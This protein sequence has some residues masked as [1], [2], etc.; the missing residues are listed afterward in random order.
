MKIIHKFKACLLMTALLPMMANAQ[1]ATV[2]A[3]DF[4]VEAGSTG[5]IE[6]NLTN[7]DFEVTAVQFDIALPQGLSIPYDGEDYQATLTS[8]SN[9]LILASNLVDGKVRFVM[10]GAL[11]GAVISGSEGAI[12]KITV[13]ADNTFDTGKLTFSTVRISSPT[14]QLVKGS[15]FDVVANPPIPESVEGV[16]LAFEELS[17]PAGGSGVLAIDLINPEYS[18]T[19][20]QFDLTLPYAMSLT[21]IEKTDRPSSKHVVTTK[22]LDSGAIRVKLLDM[23]ANN[24]TIAGKEG[25]ILNLNLATESTF[26]SGKITISNIEMSNPDMLVATPEDITLDVTATAGIENI[27]ADMQ[28]YN[29]Y[30]LQGVKV[31]Q[32]NLKKGVYIINGKKMIVK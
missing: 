19:A 16:K 20:M 5:T 26:M 4:R 10:N 11:T 18:V 31:S 8:R 32:D 22:T 23:S 12:L 6:V 3:E 29:V 7:F 15:D 21:S 24:K 28:N 25:A 14:G 2:S 30:N 13:K 9:S 27:A 17:I 1:Q